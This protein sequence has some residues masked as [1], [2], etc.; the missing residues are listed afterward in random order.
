MTSRLSAKQ[1][2]MLGTTL[3]G[4][5]ALMVPTAAKADCLANSSGT[6]VT[7]T[8]ADPDG[9]DGSATNG[10]TINVDNLAVVSG[11]LSTG[12]GSAVNNE[13]EI[14]VGAGNTAVSVGGGSRFSNASTATGDVTGNILFGSTTG[15]QINVFE[16]FNSAFGLFGDIDSA[17]ALDFTNTG[18]ITGNLTSSGDTTVDNSG[19]F[20]GDITLGAGNDTID[21]SGTL[22]GNV[23]MGAGT[24]VFNAMS[25]AAFPTG[26]LTADPLG[27]STLN[28]GA[29]GGTIGAVTNFDVMN[30]NGGAFPATWIVAA[31][32]SFSDRINV[33][34]GWLQVPDADNLGS[35]TIVNNAGPVTSGGVWF[36]N[37]ASGTYSGNMSGTGVVY[38]G[39]SGAGTTTFSGTNTY[40]GGTYID[41]STLQVTGGNALADTG[42]VQLSNSGTLDVAATEQIG[43]LNDGLQYGGTG[44]VTLSGG[45]LLINSGAFS[46]VISGANGIEKVGT[47]TL[48]LSGANTFAGAATVTGGN[49]TLQGGAAI[50]DTTA[51]VVGT[52]GTL[53]VDDPE[54]IGSLAGS[55]STVLN[56]DLTAGGDN[57]STTYSGVISGVGALT[58]EGT[59]TFTLTGANT[60]SGGTTVN[61]GTLEG[62]T[63]SL[64]G[65]ILVNAAGTLL[66]TQPA[67]GTYAGDLTGTGVLTKAGAGTLVLTGTNSGFSGT[68]NFNAGAFSI[69]AASNIGTG[70]FVFDGGTLQTTGVLSLANLITLNAGGGTFLTDADTTLTGVISGAGNLTKTGAADL[71]LT[72]ANTYTGITTIS[73]GT[74]VLQAGAVNGVSDI[75]N[76]S[77]LIFD[78]AVGGTYSGDISG[79]GDLTK[80]NVGTTTLTG[81]NTYTGATFILDGTLAVGGTGI[82]DT[83]AVTVNTPGILQMNAD[84]TIGSLA[85][86]G[87]VGGAFTLTTGGNN[88]TTTFS[89]STLR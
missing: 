82:G 15:T 47:G 77:H 3:V 23:D 38:V 78:D 9:Y 40:T 45:N 39:F 68:T 54:V 56:G 51:V 25:G 33:N 70:P 12:T 57:T 73:A 4:V 83:S 31:P 30:V 81:N 6:T 11:P 1:Y 32:V 49:L 85:G 87:T 66:F 26:T 80:I 61:G 28:L 19:T 37:T 76:S 24:N 55:G 16:N 5:G 7:C 10:L 53:Q 89:G 48:V 8:T 52:S 60:Y 71:I 14:D 17:G 20:T 41:G 34:T 88:G 62:N 63:T 67:N 84:E 72:G 75:V 59:G 43:A 74:L 65:D 86:D 21:N 64:Q 42:E 58:K 29:G 13:G 27:N 36:D 79:S 44:F 22:T 50:G 35:N 46:G 2:L 18:A 69:G